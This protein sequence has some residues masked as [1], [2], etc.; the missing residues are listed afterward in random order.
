MWYGGGEYTI[1]T[2]SKCYVAKR[3]GEYVEGLPLLRANGGDIGGGG[4]G[5]V[6]FVK[7]INPLKM[8]AVTNG[9]KTMSQTPLTAM[10]TQMCIRQK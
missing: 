6:V 1:S 4:G 8:E 9:L 2:D 10:K 7:P 5:L 3:F